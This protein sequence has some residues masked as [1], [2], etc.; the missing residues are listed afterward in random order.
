MKTPPEQMPSIET[1]FG[2]GGVFGF[3]VSEQRSKEWLLNKV[4]TLEFG[5]PKLRVG[6]VELIKRLYKATFWLPGHP[7]EPAK[8]MN[9]LG[10]T[11]P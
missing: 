8:V 5:D 1:S 11:P 2:K 6:G 3:V 10:P 7:E 9:R 4:A